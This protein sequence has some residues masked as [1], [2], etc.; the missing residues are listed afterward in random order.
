MGASSRAL[1]EREEDNPKFLVTLAATAEG[2]FLAQP[3]AVLIKDA[4]G[5]I[6]GAAGASG[7][8]G[9]ED[10]QICVSGNQA[11]AL[12]RWHFAYFDVEDDILDKTLKTD[13]VSCSPCPK[14][15][16]AL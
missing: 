14:A 6:L 4:N 3:G 1:A 9:D 11:V 12:R 15:M 16:A 13:A 2:K 5:Q 8:T 7:G 10:E